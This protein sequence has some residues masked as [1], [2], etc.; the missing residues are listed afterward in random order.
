VGL[1]EALGHARGCQW[2]MECV[3]EAQKYRKMF[4]PTKIFNEILDPYDPT[5]VQRVTPSKAARLNSIVRF[6]MTGIV[7]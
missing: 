3:Q 1:S 7:A 5:E 6:F 4:K 2:I